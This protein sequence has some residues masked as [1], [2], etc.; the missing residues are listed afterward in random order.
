VASVPSP[1]LSTKNRT[2][3]TPT[4]SV[5]VAVTVV[6]PFTVAPDEGAVMATVG[7]VLSLKTVTVIATE[8]AALPAASRATAVRVCGPLVAAFVSHATE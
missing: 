3:T 7:A 5:A 1:T 6:V 2:P 8:V 4:L